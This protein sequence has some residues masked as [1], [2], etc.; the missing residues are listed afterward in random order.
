MVTCQSKQSGSHIAMMLALIVLTSGHSDASCGNHE[1]LCAL[2][3]DE[4]VRASTRFP[5][6][7]GLSAASSEAAKVLSTQKNSFALP[8][9]ESLSNAISTNTSS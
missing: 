2:C 9:L 5:V 1:A 3:H 7:I 8:M 4:R 6:M